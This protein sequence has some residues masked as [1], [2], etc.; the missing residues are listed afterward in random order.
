VSDASPTRHSGRYGAWI[1]GLALIGLGIIFPIQ[2]LGREIYNWWA[3]FI[4]L[5]VFFTLERSYAS[6]QAGRPGEA[7]G[8]FL[9][10]LVLIALI[11]IF[12]FDLPLGQIW[13]V[14]L[15]IGGFSLL[16]SRRSWAA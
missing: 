12:L 9:G 11:V 3:L 7:T 2:N 15:I 16:F 6:L 4:L 5:P 10:A 1:P 14:F 13:P 8:P